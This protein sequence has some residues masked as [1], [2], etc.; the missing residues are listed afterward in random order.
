MRESPIYMDILEEGLE[1][2]RE[3]GRRTLRQ[4]ISKT[5]QRRFG[6]VPHDVRD[7][8]ASVVEFPRLEELV[9]RAHTCYDLNAFVDGLN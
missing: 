9:G 3:E 4:H 8:L 5:L 1:E 2:G 6:A 7:Q